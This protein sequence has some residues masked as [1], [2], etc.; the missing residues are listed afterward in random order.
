MDASLP[1][2]IKACFNA[3]IPLHLQ[4]K[5]LSLHHQMGRLCLSCF[6]I[7]RQYLLTHFLKC[8][9]NVNST[10]YCEVLLTLQASIHRK[11]AGDLA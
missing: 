5:G 6:W 4:P 9:E 3:N 7:L 8:D 2:H 11:S 1:A 10:S